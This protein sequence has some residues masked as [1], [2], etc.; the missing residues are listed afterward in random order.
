MLA[1]K[2]ITVGVTGGIAAYK[3]AELVSFL[4][5]AGSDVH[6]VMTSSACEFVTPLTFEVLTGNQVHTELFSTGSEG[7]VLHIDLAQKSDLL[8]VVPATANILGKAAN[9]IADDM[10]STIIMAA[11]CPI[12]FCP[13]MNVVMYNNPVVQRNIEQ[14]KGFGYHFVEP[15]EGRLACGTSGKGRLAD[16]DSIVHSIKKSLTPQDMAGLEVLITAGPTREPLDPVRYL[17]NRS[18][19]KMGYALARSTAQRGGKVTL[20]SGPTSL[21][22]P[23]GVEFIPVET[24]RQMFDAVMK[25]YQQS[26]VI[27]KSAAVAD[28]RPINV[29]DHKIKKDGQGMTIEMAQNPDILAELGRRKGSDQLLVGFAA[30]TNDLEQYALSKLR[31]KNADLLVANDVS[32]PGVGFDYDT[33]RVRIFGANGEVEELPLMDKNLVAH[34]ILDRVVKLLKCR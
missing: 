23:S 32:Q 13:A 26:Q 15:G 22:P 34:R 10:V 25:H 16:I 6:V 18:S 30:E 2:R 12:L 21:T 7:G 28:Y 5:K 1:G 14:L 11:S 3:A 9:G 17:T 19:G 4:V 8:L 31:R 27:I 20:V 29:S 24:A 33:N